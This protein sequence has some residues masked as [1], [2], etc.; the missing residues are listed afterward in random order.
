MAG[1]F[2]FKVVSPDG[3][4][5][6]KDIEFV[7]VPGEQGELGILPRH[8]PF[9]AGLDIGVIRYT[10]SG[11]VN[12]MAVSGGFMEVADNKVTVL[13]EAAECAEDID[14][15]RA[16]AAKERAEQRL[17]KKDPETDRKRAEFALRRA[18]ARLQAGE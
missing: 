17:K 5:F 9:I 1:T 8:A 4:V 14:L 12:R 6:N 18:S 15:E 3:A 7:V 10:L 13:A 2:N 16:K 11:K